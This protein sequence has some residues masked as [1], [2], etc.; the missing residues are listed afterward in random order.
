MSKIA[1]T[2][3]TGHLGSLVVEHLLA[4]GVSESE[5]VPLV[6]SE[7][8]GRRFAAQGMRPRVASF[9]DPGTLREALEG[10]DK[11]VL[12]SSPAMENV[13]RLR[14]LHGAVIAAHEA[15]LSHIAYVGLVDPEDYAFQLEDVELATEHSIRAAEIPFTFLRNSVYFDELIPELR[16]AL[17][18]GELL[19][20]TGDKTLNWAPRADQAAAIAA[21][22]AHGDH[23]GETLNLVS[24][25]RYTYADVAGLLSEA[26]GQQITHRST[27]SDRVIAALTAGGMDA[28]HSESMVNVFQHAIATGKWSTT[29]ADIERLSGRKG[30][31]TADYVSQILEIEAGSGT[32]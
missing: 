24:P 17:R 31:P 5:V 30:I 18:S 6:R 9:D 15:G 32:A 28:A 19:S 29:G 20:V 12:I 23:I 2:G 16:V 25:E 10:V 14:Q 3:A 27:T 26:T 8:K 22:I 11:L 4:L 1:V 21:V 7:A 13:V